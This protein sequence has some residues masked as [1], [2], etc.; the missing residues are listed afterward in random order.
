MKLTG[1]LMMLMMVA[2]SDNR[3]D[4]TSISETDS[5]APIT[6]PIVKER[7]NNKPAEK[8]S[9][10]PSSSN[11]KYSN[12]R[13]KDVTVEKV[14]L[15]EYTIRGKGQIFEANFGWVITDGQKEIKNGFQMTDA[16]APEWGNFKF[17]INLQHETPNAAL[18]LILFESSAKDGSRQHQLSIPLQ[19]RVK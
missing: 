16:G 17:T 18:T 2:C 1:V 12:V 7:E 10:N 9:A 13:F 3:E 8:D 11:N 19:L 15:N 5:V 14:G 4:T 6:P